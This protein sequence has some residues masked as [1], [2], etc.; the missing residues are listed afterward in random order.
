LKV[1]NPA[2]AGAFYPGTES[3][4]ITEIERC[5]LHE[6]GP[7]KIPKTLSNPIRSIKALIV[8]HAGYIYSGSVAAHSYYALASDGTPDCVVIIGPNHTGMG[9][10]VSIMNEGKW[11]TPLGEL[12]IN[13][14]VAKKI[15]ETSGI[16]DIDEEAHLHEHSIEVQIPFLQYI[17][18]KKI[19][20]VP[21]CMMMQDLETSINLG[22]AISKSIYDKNALV[23]ASSDM[24]HYEEGKIA[25]EKDREVIDAILKLDEVALFNIIESKMISMCGYG[26]VMSTIVYAKKIGAKKTELMSYRTSGDTTGDH[27]SVVGYASLIFS[28]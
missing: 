15:C 11:I 22:E 27:S 17:Y 19:S 16:I 6:F 13:S 26:P 3:S 5:F 28:L 7:G 24:T 10:G 18:G 4:L 2:Q 21:I 20:F 8:P 12:S 14:E 23:I 25:K 1:R 9:S